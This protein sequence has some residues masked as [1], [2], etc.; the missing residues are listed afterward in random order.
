[1]IL[2]KQLRIACCD[3]HFVGDRVEPAA[4]LALRGSGEQ[5]EFSARISFSE[6]APIVR[7][8]MVSLIE[9]D[10]VSRRPNVSSQRGLHRGDLHARERR[11]AHAGRDHSD[12]ERPE[13]GA[14]ASGRVMQQLASV[15]EPDHAIEAQR[16]LLAHARLPA[17][18]RAH[19]QHAPYA[20][21]VAR[22][23][24]VGGSSLVIAQGLHYAQSSSSTPSLR[25][26]FRV[27]GYGVVLP[28]AT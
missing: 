6:L 21:F 24:G 18:G 19:E 14:Q 15:R 5:Q 9:H 25:N 23:H 1:M 26:F 17:A 28:L 12:F 13:R 16:D 4:V 10:Q 11:R 2:R 22:E 8:E 27:D 3:D 7:G 20:S